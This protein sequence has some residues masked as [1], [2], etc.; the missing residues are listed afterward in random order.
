MADPYIGEIR[1]LGFRRV[2]N[3]WVACDGSLL[4]IAVYETLY[5]VIGTVYGGDGVTTFAVPDLR[6]RVPLSQ[7][8]G[9]GLTPRSL[10][11]VGGEVSHLLQTSE[12]PAH[13]HALNATTNAGTTATPGVN[14]HLAATSIA[15]DVVYAPAAGITAY[16][17]MAPSVGPAGDSQAHDNVMPTLVGNYCICA[18]GVYPPP[19]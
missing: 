17:V 2:P 5:T 12:M 3:G 15:T 4:S 18:N 1:L 8:N 16:G 19:A 14:V 11:E 13:S 9:S 10:G 7:G 6:G